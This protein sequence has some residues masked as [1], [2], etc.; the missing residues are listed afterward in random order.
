VN[1]PFVGNGFTRW[2]D[3]QYAL[4]TPELGLSSWQH[5]RLFARGGVLGGRAVAEAAR[6]R[7]ARR[8]RP[9]PRLD[10]AADHGTVTSE[11]QLPQLFS[12]QNVVRADR[13]AMPVTSQ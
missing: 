7:G 3:G 4:R 10:D 5:G 12:R 11:R 13:L 2:V 9:G 1:A 6:A 8:L